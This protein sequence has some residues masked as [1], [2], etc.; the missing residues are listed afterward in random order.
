MAQPTLTQ[1]ILTSILVGI[2]AAIL[3]RFIRRSS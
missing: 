3:P 2:V 1:K